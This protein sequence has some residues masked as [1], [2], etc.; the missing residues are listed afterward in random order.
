MTFKTCCKEQQHFRN[1]HR[2]RCW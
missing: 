1:C 2:R